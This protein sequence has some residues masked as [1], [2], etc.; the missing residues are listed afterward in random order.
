MDLSL[1]T[2]RVIYKYTLGVLECLKIQYM[3]FCR[4]SPLLVYQMGKVGSSTVEKSL[5]ESGVNDPVYHLH[6]LSANGIDGALKYYDT[7]DMGIPVHLQRSMCLRSKLHEMGK[8]NWRIITLVREPIS[9]EVSNIYQ[10]LNDTHPELISELGEFDTSTVSKIVY[11]KLNN[12]NEADDFACNWFDNEF[13]QAL[14]I[15][16]YT[17][18]F[19]RDKGYS[20]IKH[21]NVSVLIFRIEDMNCNFDKAINMFIGGDKYVSMKK[22]NI[23]N[24]KGYSASYKDTVKDIKLPRELCEKI[25]DSK[26]V[27]HFYSEEMIEQFIKKWTS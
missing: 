2:K 18:P 22:A 20:I 3:T 13:K 5:K 11:D 17:S 24:S 27:R 10:N 4:K 16:V 23:G 9:R 25:Y 7:L 1:K 12:F 26:Y 21:N 15:D 6:F 8:A 14:E 19:D